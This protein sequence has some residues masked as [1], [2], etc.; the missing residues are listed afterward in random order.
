MKFFAIFESMVNVGWFGAGYTSG[1]L[2]CFNGMFPIIKF[3]NFSYVCQQVNHLGSPSPQVSCLGSQFVTR[4]EGKFK[5]ALC[6][7]F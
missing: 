7:L 6:I 1:L 2:Y 3:W 4:Y 5:I